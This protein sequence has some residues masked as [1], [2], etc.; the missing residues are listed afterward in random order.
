MFCITK[1]LKIDSKRKTKNS[2]TP[3]TQIKPLTHD[4]S[5][6]IKKA[7]FS[8]SRNLP[9]SLKQFDVSFSSLKKLREKNRKNNRKISGKKGN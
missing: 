5:F 3:E 7:I 4:L 1:I 2:P 6:I 9:S 8:L